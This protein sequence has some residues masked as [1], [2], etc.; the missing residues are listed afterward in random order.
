MPDESIDHSTSEMVLAMREAL[1]FA[2]EHPFSTPKSS[3]ERTSASTIEWLAQRAVSILRSQ[4]KLPSID[5]KIAEHKR[6]LS[7]GDY[8][9]WEQYVLPHVRRLYERSEDDT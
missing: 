9:L 8:A 2:E 6:F 5:E 7:P 3:T 1:S 4:S